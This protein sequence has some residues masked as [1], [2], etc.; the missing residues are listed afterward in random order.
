[1]ARRFRF[2]LEAVL[3]YREITEDRRKREFMD[4]TRQVN[5]ER[6][7]REDMGRERTAMQ[8]DIVRGFE[9]QE[10]F[11]TVVAS[12]NTIGRLESA[13]A[14]SLRR[15]EKLRVELE[16]KRKA[17][18]AA[19]MDT[20]MMESL[21]ERRR[22]EFLREE[23]RLEQNLLDELSLQQQGRRKREE[24]HAAALEAEKRKNAEQQSSEDVIAKQ[25]PLSENIR[26]EERH[27]GRLRGLEK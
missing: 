3:R 6:L 9:K 16:N 14:E 12:Y 18:V 24:A 22:E 20:R 8:E 5:E 4:A 26:K 2:N 7:R 1:M 11:Q 27:S 23:D 13:M 17:M 15:E 21:K 19:R 10:P 25:H